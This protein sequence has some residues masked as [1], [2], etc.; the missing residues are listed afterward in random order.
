MSRKSTTRKSTTRKSITTI[1]SITTMSTT[2]KQ[3]RKLRIRRRKEWDRRQEKERVVWTDISTTCRQMSRRTFRRRKNRKTRTVATSLKANHQQRNVEKISNRIPTQ[4]CCPKAR[5]IVSKNSDAI[6]QRVSKTNLKPDLET[7]LETP[8]RL[9]RSLKSL[10][11]KE[12]DL[13]PGSWSSA[14]GY[15]PQP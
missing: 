14:D 4:I 8:K 9:R 7:C 1:T 6:E 10:T 13:R 5:S 15:P 11:A 3:R 12:N 2:P